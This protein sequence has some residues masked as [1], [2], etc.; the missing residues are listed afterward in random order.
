V[1]RGIR[2]N[3]EGKKIGNAIISAL[4]GYVVFEYLRR[5]YR[6]TFWEC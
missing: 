4:I 5:S 6:V 2:K 3:L 1:I